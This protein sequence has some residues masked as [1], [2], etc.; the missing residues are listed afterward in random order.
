MNNEVFILDILGFNQSKFEQIIYGLF[1][2]FHEFCPSY[3]PHYFCKMAILDQLPKRAEFDIFGFDWGQ[4][5]A[6]IYYSG[7][8]FKIEARHEIRLEIKDQS[9]QFHYKIL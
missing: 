4:R 2:H 8:Y 7:M 9:G 5:E 6:K 1:D 3:E